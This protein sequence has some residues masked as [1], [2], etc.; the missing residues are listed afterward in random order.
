MIARRNQDV[1]NPSVC[2]EGYGSA[3]AFAGEVGVDRGI[4]FWH[5]SSAGSRSLDCDHDLG[6]PGPSRA[7]YLSMAARSLFD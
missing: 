1:G 5:A 7:G 2:E 6:G 4:G 3:W